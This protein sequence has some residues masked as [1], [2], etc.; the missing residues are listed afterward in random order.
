M[1]GTTR[2][3]RTLAANRFPIYA[4]TFVDQMEFY[5]KASMFHCPSARFTEAPATTPQFSIA[6]NSKLV[7]AAQPM[8]V[9]TWILSPTTTPYFIES[10]VPGEP[11]FHEQQSNYNGQPHA[12]ASRFSVRHGGSGVLAFAD[13]HAEALRGDRVV[14]TSP[15]S[16]HAGKAIFP[17]GAISW[18]L[19]PSV[20]PN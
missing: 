19:K 6:M 4:P 1:S 5:E 18:C 20:N 11:K 7:S 2:W 17:G 15:D 16:G 3:H 12:F 8:V 10:G 14:E 13:G 9:S